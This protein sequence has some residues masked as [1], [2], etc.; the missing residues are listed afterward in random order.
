[1]AESQRPK[2]KT[3]MIIEIAGRPKEHINNA[4]KKTAEDFAKETK[5]V[6]VTS[7]KIR[8]PKKV[9]FENIKKTDIF[10]GFVEFHA[11]IEDFSTLVGLIFDWM[12]SSVEIVEPENISENYKELNGILNDLAGR[13]HRYDSLVKKLRAKT[14]LLAKELAKFKKQPSPSEDKKD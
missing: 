9:E 5:K 10:S 8:E 3:R 1:M 6:E 2:I 12:P 14:I 4:L 13:L 7:R 11:D